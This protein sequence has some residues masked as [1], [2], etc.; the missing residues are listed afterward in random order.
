MFYFKNL[1]T[2]SGVHSASNSVGIGELPRGQNNRG[3]KLTTNCHLVKMLGMNR[4]VPPL[5]LYAFMTYT[6]IIVLY[7]SHILAEPVKVAAEPQGPVEHSL[8]TTAQFNLYL[9]FLSQSILN[10]VIWVTWYWQ[11]NVDGIGDTGVLLLPKGYFVYVLS[12]ISKFFYTD[13]GFRTA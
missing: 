7:E 11:V 3:V 8:S 10:C 4:A 13:R 1:K 2:G 12:G 9:K 5:P 6:G